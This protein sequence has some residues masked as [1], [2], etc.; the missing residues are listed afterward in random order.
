MLS[1]GVCDRF[2]VKVDK[3]ELN[4]CWEWQAAIQER[5]YGAFGIGKKVYTSH[6]VSW[7]LANGEIPEGLHV[8]HKC[9]NRKCVNPNHLFLGTNADNVADMDAK[10]R[11]RTNPVI[12]EERHDVQLTENE[13]IEIFDKHW[14]QGRSQRQLA[15][16]YGVSRTV[17]LGVVNCKTWRHL[18]LESKLPHDVSESR[19]ALNRTGKGYNPSKLGDLNNSAV[20]TEKDVRE[21]RLGSERGLT[22]RFLAEQYGVTTGNIWA[23]VNK[24]SWKHVA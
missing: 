18:N 24:K 16:E 9:D 2:W 23:I 3:K 10:G 6:R 1:Q 11:R 17:I 13:V 7:M 8:L 14:F 5:G 20:L 19:K 12:G 21:I 4:D 22:N 15:S